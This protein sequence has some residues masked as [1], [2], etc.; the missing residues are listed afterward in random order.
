[1]IPK[2]L[3]FL[4]FIIILLVIGIVIYK[5]EK[6]ESVGDNKPVGVCAFDID[7]TITHN[8]DIAAKAIAKCRELGCKVA[9]NTAR[10]SKWYDDLNLSKLG[11]TSEE[12]E[13]NFYH[14]E[15]FQC[16][17]TDMMCFEDAIASTKVKHLQTMASRWNVDPRHIILFDDQ[18]SNIIKAKQAGFETIHANNYLGGLPVNVTEQIDNIIFKL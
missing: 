9:I 2:E 3:I 17:F 10:P 4:F 18:W 6:F 1:M 16:S 15:P 5:S 12:M 11:L 13:N 7:G 8:I 14:G